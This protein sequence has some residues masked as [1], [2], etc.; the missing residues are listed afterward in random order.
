MSRKS[1]NN[2]D[3]E[4]NR[5]IEISESKGWI[6]IHAHIKPR[7]IINSLIFLAAVLDI[8]SIIKQITMIQFTK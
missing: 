4:R 2:K 5:F 7:W 6:N 1:M 8:P 3:L